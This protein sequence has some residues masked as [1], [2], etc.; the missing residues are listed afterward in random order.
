MR[1][2]SRHTV[3]LILDIA[4][5]VGRSIVRFDQ[6][7]S[8][9]QSAE[10]QRNT[11]FIESGMVINLFR[12]GSKR[13]SWW[14]KTRPRLTFMLC[15]SSKHLLPICRFPD[16][17]FLNVEEWSSLTLSSLERTC[18]RGS[19]NVSG[20]TSNNVTFSSFLAQGCDKFEGFS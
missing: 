13:E 6:K 9:K 7:W 20:M 19:S 3:P 15:S 17:L 16:A 5:T 14:R 4:S 2:L 8:E 10:L 18:R 11:F 12:P 1:N